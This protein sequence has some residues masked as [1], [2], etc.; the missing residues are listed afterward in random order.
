M[1]A[2]TGD[3]VFARNRRRPTRLRR[4]ITRFL[5]FS[6]PENPIRNVSRDKSRRKQTATTGGDATVSADYTMV[7]I[8]FVP[9]T[10]V[11]GT[12]RKNKTS[13][14]NPASRTERKIRNNSYLLVFTFVTKHFYYFFIRKPPSCKYGIL[15]KRQAHL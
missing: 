2:L 5:F 3:F 10:L 4:K 8:V 9:E 11:R 14:Q 6:P 13:K 1:L 15:T 7:R 12:T